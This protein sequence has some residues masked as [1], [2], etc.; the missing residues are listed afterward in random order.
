MFLRYA[1]ATCAVLYGALLGYVVIVFW[2]Y[3]M[4]HFHD[5]RWLLSVVALAGGLAVFCRASVW[6]SFAAMTFVLFHDFVAYQE[7]TWI[8]SIFRGVYR[9]SRL[10][11]VPLPLLLLPIFAVVFSLSADGRMRRAIY[12][13]RNWPYHK[14]V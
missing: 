3:R 13:L 4:Y 12:F 1:A 6:W 11:I 5:I 2:W 8:G 9:Y 10:D 7:W 14:G